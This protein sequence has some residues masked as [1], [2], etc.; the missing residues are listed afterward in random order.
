MALIPPG[1]HPV[2]SYARAIIDAGGALQLLEDGDHAA[3]ERL[4]HEALATGLTTHD[5][6][7]VAQVPAAPP[8][9]AVDAVVTESRMIT[10]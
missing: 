4:A 3:A 7:I 1:K 10:R 9:I 2:H 5:M 6:P 8:E